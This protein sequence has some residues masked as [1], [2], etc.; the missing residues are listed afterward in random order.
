MFSFMNRGEETTTSYER[1]ATDEEVDRIVEGLKQPYE[2][3]PLDVKDA[4]TEELNQY[5]SKLKP[6]FHRYYR[7]LEE[8]P[9]FNKNENFQNMVENYTLENEW[10]S[11]CVKESSK[12][13]NGVFLSDLW[14]Q[15]RMTQE[16]KFEDIE[17][18]VVVDNALQ[19]EYEIEFQDNINQFMD[20][21]RV[22]RFSPYMRYL[23]FNYNSFNHSIYIYTKDY[24]YYTSG[25]PFYYNPEASYHSDG[26][27]D[28]IMQRSLFN[29]LRRNLLEFHFNT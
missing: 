11:D 9:R 3:L 10:V 18:I 27:N 26:D 24:I 6:D 5:L 23:P 19:L 13:A 4:T 7:K 12:Y 25:Y 20:S 29:V 2:S 1:T 17:F 8:D 14:M 21:Y 28:Y 15:D 16:E 22:N